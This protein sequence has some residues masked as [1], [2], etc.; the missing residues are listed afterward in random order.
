MTLTPEVLFLFESTQGLLACLQG[1]LEV[2]RGHQGVR[3]P[4]EHVAQGRNRR[5]HFPREVVEGR[6]V[7]VEGPGQ[8][9]GPFCRFNRSR[10]LIWTK[11]EVLK[12]KPMDSRQQDRIFQ[13]GYQ[14]VQSFQ[15]AFVLIAQSKQDV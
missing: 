8:L 15:V 6:D 14:R 13:L 2:T 9:D 7:V 4:L 10:I 12:D 5:R 1:R 3:Q 11:V